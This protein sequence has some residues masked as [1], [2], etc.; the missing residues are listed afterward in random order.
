MFLPLKELYGAAESEART[1]TVS[2]FKNF[3][4]KPPLPEPGPVVGSQ[5]GAAIEAAESLIAQFDSQSKLAM[6]RH[7]NRKIRH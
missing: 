2:H 3:P 1:G 5:D 6:P 7:E 4:P